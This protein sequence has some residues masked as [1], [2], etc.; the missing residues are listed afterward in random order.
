MTKNF[1]PSVPFVIVSVAILWAAYHSIVQMRS[2]FHNDTIEHRLGLAWR[3]KGSFDEL[4]S[5]RG[6]VAR[7]EAL[8]T[9]NPRT[10]FLA[11]NAQMRWVLNGMPENKQEL[12]DTLTIAEHY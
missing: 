3:E 7:N 1:K 6:L 10:F 11:G 2:Y 4:D 12:R 9:A 8:T 5:I